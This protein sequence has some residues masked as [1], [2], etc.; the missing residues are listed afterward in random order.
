MSADGKKEV[1]RCAHRSLVVRAETW[2][3]IVR[4]ELMK[5]GL[6]EVTVSDKQGNYTRRI[7]SGDLSELTVDNLHS[8]EIESIK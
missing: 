1:T 5:S 7:A 2:Q 6:F 8:G 3:G 4:V